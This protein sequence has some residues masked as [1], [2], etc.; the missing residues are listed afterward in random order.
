MEIW[1][2]VEKQMFGGKNEKVAKRFKKS[3]WEM[4]CSKLREES[5]GGRKIRK[6]SERQD[7]GTEKPILGAI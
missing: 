1:Y 2:N 7:E 6:P 3:L 4:K 5:I